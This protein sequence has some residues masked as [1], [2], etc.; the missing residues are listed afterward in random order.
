VG[1]IVN[2]GT[3]GAIVIVYIYIIRN[4]PELLL[5][6]YSN[7]KSFVAESEATSLGLDFLRII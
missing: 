4:H 6:S 7:I 1:E 2:S 5:R 3:S